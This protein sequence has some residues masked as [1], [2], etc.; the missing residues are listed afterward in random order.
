MW[1]WHGPT[2]VWGQPDPIPASGP[3]I[4]A[5]PSEASWNRLSREVGGRLVKVRSPLAA[6]TD[7]PSSAA[8]A[9]VFKD[10]QNPYYLGDE[11]G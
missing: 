7:A 10:L 8:C 2:R 6:C 9:K 5:W 1:S 11:L 4:P 3:A